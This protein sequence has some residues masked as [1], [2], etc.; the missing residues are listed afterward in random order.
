MNG[1]E[2]R[3]AI[4]E[5]LRES[6]APIS[7]KRLADEYTVTRQII[8]A[9]IALLRAAGHRITAVNRGYILE[10]AVSGLL[11]HVAVK[12]DAE[13]IADEFYAVVDHGGQ[14][15]DVIVEHPL[16]GCLSANMHI[17]SRYEADQFILRTKETGALPLSL[18]TEGVHIHTIA[19]K[20]EDT[21]DRIL[22]ALSDLGILVEGN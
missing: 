17:T 6:E 10:T 14:V 16:Y 4:L 3:A 15:L 1:Q 12:H 13:A 2:R 9:D 20:D 8:V 5:R 19:V 22:R 21:F 18:L 11:K 7:A